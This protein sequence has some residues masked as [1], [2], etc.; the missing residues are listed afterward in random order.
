MT[1]HSNFLPSISRTE[2]I[3]VTSSQTLY[4]LV[5]QFNDYRRAEILSHIKT[6]HS[7]LSLNSICESYALDNVTHRLVRSSVL[8]FQTVEQVAFSLIDRLTVNRLKRFCHPGVWCF[9]NLTQNDIR[10]P[11]MIIQDHR[12]SLCSLD[13]CNERLLTYTNSCP[14]MVERVR[15]QVKTTR[16]D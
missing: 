5:D 2:K 10:Y 11:I 6:C 9:G 13:R 4:D 3:Q 16:L 12:R 1:S 7:D 14:S 15:R 8:P